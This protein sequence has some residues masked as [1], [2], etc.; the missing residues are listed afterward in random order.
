MLVLSR[1]PRQ[2]VLVGSDVQIT[3]LDVEGDRV[4]LGITA[5]RELRVLRQ[6]LEDSLRPQLLPGPCPGYSPSE[7]LPPA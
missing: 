2:V 7:P 5:P 1:R 6:E 4:R 3:V